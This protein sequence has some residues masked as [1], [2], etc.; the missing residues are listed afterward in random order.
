MIFLRLFRAEQN[1]EGQAASWPYAAYR[2]PGAPIFHAEA[3]GW[4]LKS[5]NLDLLSF[6][7]VHYIPPFRTVGYGRE[8]EELSAVNDYHDL[9]AHLFPHTL[10]KPSRRK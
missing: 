1:P 10:P 5:L 8:G 3:S 4:G 7:H 9:N 6:N 2:G